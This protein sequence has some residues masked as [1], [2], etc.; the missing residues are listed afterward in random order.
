MPKYFSFNRNFNISTD[1][2]FNANIYEI[3]K[4]Q[5][6]KPVK[7]KFFNYKIE[8]KIIITLKAQ[9]FFLK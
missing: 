4:Y 8:K 5:I 1:M 2:Y 9:Q 3:F 7:R 6:D